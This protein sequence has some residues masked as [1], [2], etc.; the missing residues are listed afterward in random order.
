[1]VSLECQYL[2]YIYCFIKNKNF[3]FPDYENQDLKINIME[4]K[5]HNKLPFKLRN[6]NTI[7]SITSKGISLIFNNKFCFNIVSG[8]LGMPIL[9]YNISLELKQRSRSYEEAL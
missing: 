2:V 9:R 7:K 3:N 5:K 1:M 4:I 8:P 6:S